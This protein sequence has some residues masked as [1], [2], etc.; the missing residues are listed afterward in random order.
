ML[1]RSSGVLMHIT[2]KK[3]KNTAITNNNTVI[4]N[5]ITTAINGKQ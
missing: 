5:N 4:N 3:D 1:T 2:G